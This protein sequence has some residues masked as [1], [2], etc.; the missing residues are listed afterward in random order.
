MHDRIAISR[1]KLPT[2]CPPLDRLTFAILGCAVG[3][4]LPDGT[5]VDRTDSHRNDRHRLT[6]W[7]SLLLEQISQSLALVGLDVEEDQIGFA[8][9]GIEVELPEQVVLHQRKRAEQERA[10]AECQDDGHCLVFRAVEIGEPL[11][12]HVGQPAGE[13]TPDPADERQRCE[14]QDEQREADR[15]GEEESLSD[16]PNLVDREKHCA[17]Y[18]GD[19]RN[20]GPQLGTF[21]PGGLIRT[22]QY[23]E[24]WNR[25]HPEQRQ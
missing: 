7:V 4:N 2:Q 8:G 21:P 1:T 16:L 12:P 3:Q 25:A 22:P 20:P 24:W 19:P 17:D 9:T 23:L 13:P 15:S 10:E 5:A 14:P 11:S 18:Q 6:R